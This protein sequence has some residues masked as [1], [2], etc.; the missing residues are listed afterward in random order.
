MSARELEGRL[1]SLREQ[2]ERHPSVSLKDREH[3][4]GFLEQ[5]ERRG[6]VDAAAPDGRVGEAVTLAAERFDL[7]HPALAATLQSIGVALANMGI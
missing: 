7:G 4:E 1:I 2:L 6:T 5:V 3:L